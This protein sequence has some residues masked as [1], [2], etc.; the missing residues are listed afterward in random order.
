[1]RYEF[2][3]QLHALMAENPDVVFITGDLGFGI[4]DKVREDYPDRFYNPGAAEQV[5]MSMAVGF[6]LCG[7]V[8][9]CYSITPFLLF[10]PFETIRTYIAHEKIPVIMVGS[11]R[12]N[13][14]AHDEFSHFAG[15]DDI[16]EKLPNIYCLRTHTELIPG[17]VK[18]LVE[19]KVPV[20]LNLKR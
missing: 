10:R 2:F 8:P 17:T 11:G 13:D 18:A 14:Y 15:D 9:V 19:M 3:K 1:M 6:A 7:K 5:M 16:I 12:N 20:Y 4:A